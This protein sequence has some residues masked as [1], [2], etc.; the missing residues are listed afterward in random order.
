MIEYMAVIE[1]MGGEISSPWLASIEEVKEWAYVLGFKKGM[2]F[3]R[4]KGG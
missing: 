1:E 2:I 3:Q 4:K